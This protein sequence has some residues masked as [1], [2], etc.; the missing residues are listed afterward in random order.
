MDFNRL[1][2]PHWS[3]IFPDDTMT[4]RR[5]RG[6]GDIL[7]TGLYICRDSRNIFSIQECD[8]LRE[9]V[10]Q[11]DVGRIDGE[12]ASGFFLQSLREAHRNVPERT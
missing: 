5:A 8:E 6:N 4:M 7:A 12:K 1:L 9:V 2:F 10:P 11:S 3:H